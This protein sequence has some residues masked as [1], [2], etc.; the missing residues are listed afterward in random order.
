MKGKTVLI[1]GAT[2]GIGRSAAES[3]AGQGARV[4]VVGRNPAK[5]EGVVGEIRTATGSE[6]VEGLVADLSRPAEVAR[7]AD[8]FRARHTRL[9]VLINNAG[10]IFSRRT[11]TADGREATWALNHLSY[12]G[13]TLALVEVLK[14]SAPARIINVASNAHLRVRRLNLAEPE[15]ARGYSAFGAYGHSKLA[16]VMF[17]YALARRL[18]GSGVTANAMHPGLVS[19]GF[20]SNNGRLWELLYVVI[21]ALGR[22]PAEGADTLV[23]LASA[24]ELAQASGQYFYNRRPRRTSPA[25]YNEAAQEQLWSLSEETLRNATDAKTELT[26]PATR[27]S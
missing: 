7:L 10:A 26:R 21:N 15:L 14:A 22:S 2:S 13:L 27:R 9:D 19:T 6:A 17:T 23:W 8:E 25:S 5:T 12:F 4:V 3:L 20:G 16:N 11:L 18:A 24:P 1:T